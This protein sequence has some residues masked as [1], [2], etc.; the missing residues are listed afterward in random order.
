MVQRYPIHKPIGGR[1]LRKMS[2]HV[3]ETMKNFQP[4]RLKSLVKAKQQRRG[5]NPR[6]ISHH[7]PIAP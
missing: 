3:K 4:V 2:F 6:Y 1:G 7:F 5:C